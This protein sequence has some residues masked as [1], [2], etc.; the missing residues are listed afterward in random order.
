MKLNVTV[1]RWL[2]FNNLPLNFT[3]SSKRT[4]CI[5]HFLNV[6]G[7]TNFL[8]EVQAMQLCHA[9]TLCNVNHLSL[10]TDK[11]ALMAFKNTFVTGRSLLISA[12]SRLS[13]TF[14]MMSFL[15]EKLCLQCNISLSIRI[16]ISSRFTLPCKIVMNYR[17]AWIGRPGPWRTIAQ[18]IFT[19]RKHHWINSS[20][21]EGCV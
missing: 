12:T 15:P 21:D 13:H 17:W 20:I 11:A 6:W 16:W 5:Y 9:T 14:F 8:I 7:D 1:D 10:L 3:N 4:G 2:I 19:A 18:V